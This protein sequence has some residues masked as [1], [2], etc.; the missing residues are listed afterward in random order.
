MR[1]YEERLG[2][3]A[4]VCL[5]RILISNASIESSLPQF[6]LCFQSER[7]HQIVTGIILVAIV[8]QVLKPLGGCLPSNSRAD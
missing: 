8:H 4:G 1:H 2:G 7:W 5:G 6:Q 3:V